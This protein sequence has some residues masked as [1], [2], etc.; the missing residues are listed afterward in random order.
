[1][2]KRKRKEHKIIDVNEKTT[3]MTKKLKQNSKFTMKQSRRWR[4]NARLNMQPRHVTNT[5]GKAYH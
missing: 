2:R 3:T 1:M 4:L 5:E